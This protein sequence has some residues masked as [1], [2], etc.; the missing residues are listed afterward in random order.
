MRALTFDKELN[1]RN[2]P[3][4]VPGP[5]EALIRVRH[6]GICNTDLEI[7]KGYMDFSGIPGHEFVGEVIDSRDKSLTGKRVIG[8]INIGCGRCRLCR[9]HLSRHCP[10]R[11]VLGILNHDGA[12][13]EYMVLPNRNLHIVPDCVSD[14][15]A[16]FTEPLAA[17]CEILEQIPAISGRKVGIIGDGKLAQI[18][19]RLLRLEGCDITVFGKHKHKL[20]LLAPLKIRTANADSVSKPSF[21]YIIEASGNPGGMMK[22]MALVRPRG[23]IVLKSTTHHDS[24][25]A[26]N[27]LVIQE[28]TVVGSRCGPFVPAIRL[29]EGKK[30]DLNPLITACY[31]IHAWRQAF[32]EALK[33]ES[34]KII[35]S[36]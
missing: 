36:M 23:T 29:L 20:A 15:E 6:A 22:A 31:P 24:G 17:A 19:A 18:I 11:D 13:A 28:I 25:P 4:P 8:E 32:E 12:F 30:I 34:L 16:V 35:I 9:Q 5:D 21:D 1:E 7:L 26:L 3:R 10:G 33:K 14:L 27:A 2:R